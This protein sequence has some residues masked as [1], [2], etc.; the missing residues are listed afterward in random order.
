MAKYRVLIVDDQH[1]V[2]VVLATGVRTLGEEF[3]VIEMPSAEEALLEASRRPVDLIVS[4]VRL[5]GMSGLELVGRIRARNPDMKIILITGVEDPKIRRQVADAGASAFFY[6]PVPLADFLD[7]VERCLGIVE[8]GLPMPPVADEPLTSAEAPFPEAPTPTLAES[9]AGLRQRLAARAAML[10]DDTGKVVARAGNFAEVDDESVL[11][12][13]L[14]VAL[15]TSL[16]VSL[17]MEAEMPDNLLYFAGVGYNLRL[18]NVGVSHALLVVTE[19]MAEHDALGDV[20]QAMRAAVLDLEHSLEEMGVADLSLDEVKPPLPPV[21]DEEVDEEEM[22]AMQ[23]VLG[24]SEARIKREEA[25]A[26]WDSLSEE[27]EMVVDRTDGLSYE[28]A[29]KLGLAPD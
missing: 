12:T 23:A 19:A 17:V 10:L 22:V 7:A 3:E 8:T 29:R 24:E 9:L 1:D 14:L 2:R 13:A 18:V 6:K 20:A 15:S 16:K 11:T 5:P 25:D 26:F 4:D 21:L 27:S 28:E